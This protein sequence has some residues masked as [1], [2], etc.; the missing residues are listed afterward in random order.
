MNNFERE[1]SGDGR[2]SEKEVKEEGWTR[3][4]KEETVTKEERKVEEE[5]KEVMV[6]RKKKRRERII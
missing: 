3:E 2:L 6:I 1:D 4:I 5:S